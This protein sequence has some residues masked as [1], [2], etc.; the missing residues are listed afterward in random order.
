MLPPGKR[1]VGTFGRMSAYDEKTL[2]L[3][4]AVGL[5]VRNV[6]REIDGDDKNQWWAPIPY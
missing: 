6:P 3:A 4:D 1:A 5:K 2:A